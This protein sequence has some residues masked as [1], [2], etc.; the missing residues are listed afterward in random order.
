M[1]VFNQKNYTHNT[2]IHNAKTFAYH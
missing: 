2:I 1:N